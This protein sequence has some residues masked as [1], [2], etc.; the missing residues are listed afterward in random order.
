MVF[1]NMVHSV[2]CACLSWAFV[3]F[4]VRP[5]FPF[6]IKGRMWDVI[7]SIPH[8]CL[9]IYFTRLSLTSRAHIIL[10]RFLNLTPNV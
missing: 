7:V 3:K 2:N 9:S 8:H 4:C 5:S 6:G 1:S 10:Q